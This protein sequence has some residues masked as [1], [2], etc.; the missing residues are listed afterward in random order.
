MN[1]AD[2]SEVE[3]PCQVEGDR[4]EMSEYFHDTSGIGPWRSIGNN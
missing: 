3:T 2:G 1:A 4:F